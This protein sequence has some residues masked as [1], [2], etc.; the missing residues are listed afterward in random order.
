MTQCIIWADDE[1]ARLCSVIGHVDAKRQHLWQGTKLSFGLLVGQIK[2]KM[3]SCDLGTWNGHVLQFL[4][5]FYRL[6]VPLQT[7][8]K[9]CKKYSAM[10]NVLFNM[11]SQKKKKN[12]WKRAGSTSTL[13][14]SFWIWPRAPPTIVAWARL[15]R[16]RSRWL[17]LN[18]G[19]ISLLCTKIGN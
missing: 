4:K 19:D 10:I 9:V 11:F 2:E 3:T 12:L 15:T 16:E 14:P 5:T 6:K 13:S 17:A 18:I 1:S 7:N 8:F